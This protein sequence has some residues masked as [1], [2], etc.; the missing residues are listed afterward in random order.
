MGTYL[1]DKFSYLHFAVGIIVYYWNIPL[2]L[3][4]VLHTIFEIVEN[5]ETGIHVINT[6]IVFWPGGKPRA[7]T[8]LNMLGDTICAMIGWTSASFLDTA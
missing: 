6:Y 5:T 1:F 2:L 4:F 3:W 8:L 7:D